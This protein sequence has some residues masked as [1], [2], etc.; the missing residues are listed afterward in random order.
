MNNIQLLIAGTKYSGW[1]AVSLTRSVETIA[2]QFNITCT[3]NVGGQAVKWPI[4]PDESCEVRIADQTLIVGYV[5]KVSL[6]IDADMHGIAVSGRD[7]TGDLVDCAAV[8]EPAQ[9]K[10]ITILKLCQ[11]LCQ[12]FGIEVVMETT[13]ETPIKVFKLEPGEKAFDAIDR[14]C[15]LVGVLP[16]QG[17]GRLVLAHI[18]KNKATTP[19]VLGGNLLQIQSDYDHSDRFSEYIVSGQRAGKDSD[20]GKQVAHVKQTVKDDGVKRY[21][22]YHEAADGQVDAEKAARQAEW[23]RQTRAARS[24]TFDATVAGWLQ[25]DGKVWDINQLVQVQAD[26]VGITGELLIAAVEY[27]LDGDNGETTKLNL[28]RPDAFLPDPK[29]V[30]KAQEVGEKQDKAAAKTAKAAKKG[31]AAKRGSQGNAVKEWEK[32]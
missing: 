5:D 15:K 29:E 17:L 10:D 20:H 28:K 22:P 31:K 7:K 14:A 21:R 2:G 3:E 16:M 19:L 9:W 11:I 24:A 18:G 8:H 27:S 4:K 6:G 1:T 13:C 32:K 23:E 26:A 25:E 12:P 30:E